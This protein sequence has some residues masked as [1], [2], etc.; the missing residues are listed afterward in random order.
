VAPRLSVVIPCY[1]EAETLDACV[2]QVR[3]IASDRLELEILIVDDAST[4]GSRAVADLLAARHAEVRVVRHEV[5]Q[6]KG[7][8][9]RTGFREV[10]GDY[11][12]VQDADLE[13]DPRDLVR[14]LEP[15]E[16]GRADVVLGSRYLAD[17]PHRVLYFWH[18][19]GNRL[20]TVLSNVF[21]D[22]YLTDME[23]CY[24]V[25]KREIIQSIEIEENRFGF[26]PEIVAKLADRRLRIYEAGIHYSPR[27]YEEGKKIGISDAFRALYCIIRYNAQSAPI[28]IQFAVYCLIGGL[29]ALANL[30]IFALLLRMGLGVSSSAAIAFGSAA[31]INYQLCVN[32]L[33]HRNVRWTQPVEWFVYAAV[34]VGVGWCDLVL[35]RSLIEAGLG[36]LF[37]K[38]IAA[39]SLPI[40]NFA[41]RRYLVFPSKG[42]GAWKPTYVARDGD[43][44]VDGAD[45][46]D[47]EGGRGDV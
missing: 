10:T 37:S 33:F 16:A 12:A 19:L 44:V 30:L 27:T 38:V 21:T 45:R 31:L 35:T 42:R 32:F 34:V 6:G 9:L 26:E 46:V 24:K 8:A 36:A 2:R 17:R 14:L 15:L 18:S 25:F 11:V 47:R 13:Y 5:N 40:L 1:N 3:E 23:T 43:G 20:L 7:A 29:S 28:G 41:A 39:A 22:L 4:D